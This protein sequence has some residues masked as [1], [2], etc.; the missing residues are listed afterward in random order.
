MLDFY[1]MVKEFLKLNHQAMYNLYFFY[2]I[3]METGD[4]IDVVI[5]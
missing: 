2:E 4:E 3:G 1:L 5:E